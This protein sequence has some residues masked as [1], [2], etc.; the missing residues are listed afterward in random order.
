LEVDNT[1]LTMQQ[2]DPCGPA[3]ASGL[4]EGQNARSRPS[5]ANAAEQVRRIQDTGIKVIVLSSR[6]PGCHQQTFEELNRHGFSF[7]AS[8]WPPQDG[9]PDVF[10]PEGGTLPVMYEDGVFLVAGQDKGLMLKALLDK[11]GEPYP[12]L[13]I[14]VDQKRDNLNAVMKTFSFSGTKVHAWRYTH[15][16]T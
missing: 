8:A 5:Q 4:L 7:A 9:Y 3:P 15:E 11:S 6:G 16:D 12:V 13:I 14:V 10:T 1:L 2:E